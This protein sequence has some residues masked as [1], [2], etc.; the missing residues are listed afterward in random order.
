MGE[1]IEKDLSYRLQ[2]AMMEVH[3]RLGP[4]FRE[5]TYRQALMREL[6]VR[7]IKFETEKTIDVCYSGDVIDQYRLDLLVEGKIIV[8]M[9]AVSEI[10]SRFE[11]QILS[12]LRAANL[13]LGYLVNFGVEKLAMKRILNPHL[14]RG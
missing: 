2:G 4:G 10:H 8:E 3:F 7:Q 5:E 1:L 14:Q 12:Y 9:K 13:E 11:A 6:S